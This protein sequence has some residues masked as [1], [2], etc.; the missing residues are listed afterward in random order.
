MYKQTPGDPK[1]E[2]YDGNIT[3]KIEWY[4]YPFDYL[5]PNRVG[6]DRK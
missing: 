4:R 6:K 5:N 2:V 1:K 3:D